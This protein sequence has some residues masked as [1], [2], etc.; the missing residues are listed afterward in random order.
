MGKSLLFLKNIK[1]VSMAGS[2]ERRE[3]GNKVT[4]V[5][6]INIGK[7]SFIQLRITTNYT[8]SRVLDSAFGAIHESSILLP[9]TLPYSTIYCYMIVRVE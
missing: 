3:G 1:A 2:N 5:T 9:Q 8:N 7:K 4:E 6:A